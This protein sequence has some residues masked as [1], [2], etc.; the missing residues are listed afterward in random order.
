MEN[1][2]QDT[3]KMA[4]KEDMCD[5]QSNELIYIKSL[6]LLLSDFVDKNL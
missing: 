5:L 4:W 6:L 1:N 3:T 2:I